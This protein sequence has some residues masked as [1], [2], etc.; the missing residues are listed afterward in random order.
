MKDNRQASEIQHQMAQLRGEVREDVEDIFDSARAYSDWRYYVNRHPWIC[1]GAAVAVGYF[2]V[3]ARVEIRSPDVATLKKLARQNRLVVEANPA[4]QPRRSLLASAGSL[5]GSLVVRQAMS[6]AG[7]KLAAYIE[8]G[9]AG[10]S[11]TAPENV[12]VPS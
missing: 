7:Q 8:A 1:V 3:P 5:L 9:G 2:L 10:G 4:A 11:R 6:F 12:E